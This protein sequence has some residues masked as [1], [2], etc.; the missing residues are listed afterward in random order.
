M[1]LLM[2]FTLSIGFLQDFLRISPLIRFCM[3]KK[4]NIEHLKV[5]G[6]LS[7][8]STLV[9]QRKK[10]DARAR[11]C[12]FLGYKPGMKGFILHDLSSRETFVS[13]HVHF[14]EQ[15][16]PFNQKPEP[17]SKI[18]PP[19]SIPHDPLDFTRLTS[20]TTQFTSTTTKLTSSKH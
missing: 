6:C 10:F 8:A 4:A 15:I 11:R 3:V 13:R 14:Y 16:F 12:V 19:L 20:S 1:R 9:S 17:S 2:L 18:N 5:F 7:F